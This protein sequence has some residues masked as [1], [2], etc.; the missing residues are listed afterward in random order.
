MLT[1]LFVFD[2]DGT[3]IKNHRAVR[4]EFVGAFEDVAGVTL[5]HEDGIQFAGMTDRGIVR[6]ILGHIGRE[7]EFDTFFPRFEE[8]FIVRLDAIYKTH[9]DPML[10]PGV[11][12]LLDALG[13]KPHAGLALGTGNCRS[14]CEI[15]LQRFGLWDRFGAG[16]FGGDHEIRSDAIQAAVD[17]AR[18]KL[19]WSDGEVWVIGDTV[20]DIAA[21]RA[22]KAKVLAVATGPDSYED[23]QNASPD[24]LLRSLEDT[25]AILG[26]LGL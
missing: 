14:T 4:D 2:V 17:D 3:M 5:G 12:E 19:G 23:L 6:T 25:S 24:F 8:R 26:N 15:K 22:I 11:V 7:D 9:P 21:A 13:S 18:I 16:G 1:H 10:L 20:R